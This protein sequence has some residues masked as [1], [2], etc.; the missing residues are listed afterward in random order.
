MTK[1]KFCSGAERNTKITNY[2]NWWKHEHTHIVL[3][4]GMGVG[5]CIGSYHGYQ[6]SKKDTYG[7]CIF[8]T[9]IFGW[10]G[11]VSGYLLT[12]FCPV[13]VP[14][15]IVATIARQMEPVIEPEKKES[16]IYTIRDKIPT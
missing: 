15:V 11:G 13:T 4:A 14:I 9:V 7:Q 10:F 2:T 1:V 16:D 6:E 3:T 12:M 5:T 8:S